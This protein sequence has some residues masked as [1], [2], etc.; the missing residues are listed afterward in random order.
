[1]EASLNGLAGTVKHTAS[2]ESIN[3]AKETLKRFNDKKD[4]PIVH[5]RE[6]CLAAFELAFDH[7]NEKHFHYAVDGVQVLLRDQTYHDTITEETQNSLPSQVL[8]SMTGIDEW[9]SQLQCKCITLLV[10][11]VCS[12]EL[13]VSMS[14]VEQCIQIYKRLYG[15]S[16]E[17][18]V[19]VACRAATTQSLS[20]YFSNRYAACEAQQEA[21]AVYMDV[22]KLLEELCAE[23]EQMSSAHEQ[24][25]ISLDAI[26][27]LLTTSNLRILNHQPFVNLL[28]EKLCPLIILLLG[29]PD[30]G[31]S[32][33]KISDSGGN[34]DPVGEG[35]IDFAL[36]PS[37]VTNPHTWRALYQ[38]VD[39]LIR[40]MIYDPSL[41]SSLEALFHKAFLFPRL[42]Q[43]SEALKLIKKILGDGS[44]MSKIAKSCVATKSLSIWRMLMTCIVECTNPQLELSIDSVK[45]VVSMLDGMKQLS[46]HRFFTDGE[47]KLIGDTFSCTEDTIV[48][49][50]SLKCSE[51]HCDIS[52]VEE[53]TENVFEQTGNLVEDPMS[54]KLRKLEQKFRCA[55]L[56]T[57]RSSELDESSERNTAK[58]FVQAF[59]ENLDIIAAPKN[60]LSI[61]EAILQFASDFY[62]NF[63]SV[64]A[65]A[66]KSRSKIQ[67]EFLNT[68]AIYLTTYAALC[69]ISRPETYT[70]EDLKKTVLNSGSVVHVA[71][72]WLEKV[73]DSLK[74]AD[75]HASQIT[76]ILKNV[77]NDFDGQTKG[78]LSDVEKLKRIKNRQE[79]V[80]C[81]EERNVARWMISSAWH[82][83]IDVLSTFLAVKEK[84]KT[85]EKIREAISVSICGM[86]NLC[87]VAQVLGLESRCG[88]IFEQLVETSC[89]LEDLRDDAIAADNEKK[90]TCTSREHLL[91]M[92]LVLDEARIAIHASACWKHIIRCSEYVWELEKYI[93]GALCYE[94]PSRLKFLRRKTEEKED[95]KEE[96]TSAADSSIENALGDEPNLSVH[97]LNRAICVLIAK[98]DRFYSQVCRELCLPALHDLCV[99]I[100]SSS[101]NR[102]FYSAQKH[103]HL[104]APVSL[105]SRISDI[106]STLS[107]RPLIHQMFIYPLV[108]AHFVKVCQCDQESRI[109]ASALAE[110]VT[111]L[112]LAESPGMSFNQTLIVPFQTASCSENC[113]EE[114]KEQ[115]LS[116]LSQ[117]VLSQ[118]DKIGSGWKPL[119]GS[120]K[121]VGAAR[122]EKVHWCA[123]D[124]ISS[125]LRIDS[126]PILSSSI[127]ECVPCVVNLLQNSEDSSE[128]SSAALR[129]LPNIYS[130]IL[131]LYS[132]PHIPN[133]HLLHRS[134]LRSKCLDTVEMEQDPL[135][136]PH[137]PLPWDD[138]QTYEI[139]A[140]ELFLTFMDQI[141][142][143]LLTSSTTTQ[144]NLLDMIGRLLVDISSKPLGGDSGGVC[145]SAVIL[146]Y[147]QKWIRRPDVEEVKILKQVIGAC[148]QTVIDM[149][150]LEKMNL[151]KDRLLRDIC[152][153]I[154]ECV[155]FD[156]TC[157][158]APA[159]F[160]LIAT[161]SFTF[162]TQQWNIFSHFLATASSQSLRHIRLLNSFFVRSSTDENGDIGDVTSFNPEKLTFRQM[163]A[164]IQ[165][166]SSKK[167]RSVKQDEE[168]DLSS[169]VALIMLSHGADTH[170]LEIH[171]IV[172]ALFTHC[173]LLQLIASILLSEDSNPKLKAS[174]IGTTTPIDPKLD[175]SIYPVLYSILNESSETSID[176]DT[177]PAVGSLLSRMLGID[178]ANLLKIYVSSNLIKTMSLLRRFEKTKNQ[179]LLIE[180]AQSVKAR[181]VELKNVEFEVSTRRSALVTREHAITQ[182]HLVPVE[183]SEENAYKLV[184]QEFVDDALS[185]Y[186]KHRER[187]KP[188]IPDRRNPFQ[189]AL[190]DVDP[191]SISNK[192]QKKEDYD[193]VRLA[194]H[195]D[196]CLVPLRYVA[197]NL[198]REHLPDFLPAITKI[199]LSSPDLAIRQLTVDFMSRLA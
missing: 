127:L 188:F 109:A 175:D 104:T 131:Y 162:S 29:I 98:V 189:H 51:R 63:C 129:L 55:P 174:L 187:L 170:R 80:D 96:K 94:K 155:L 49:S 27:A 171:S 47:R 92:Q 15:K 118:A 110:V 111:R 137:G 160:T 39:Q 164:A 2:K 99:A 75:A 147:V 191:T 97:S 20:A 50:F 146:P 23:V 12:N 151:W 124:V 71:N 45:T 133:Y 197:D 95:D 167:G 119:F 115:L 128:I 6:K 176:F 36:A 177:R 156:K 178:H 139:A 43:R 199:V 198:L 158:V 46:T 5:L 141:C 4:V 81:T 64:H 169:G 10:E 140:V 62:E 19:Q 122:D 48:N 114:T 33:T 69:Y 196:I 22:G 120:L 34:E 172:S 8:H 66:Y 91:A 82:M 103:I 117:L 26:C 173:L 138:K 125:Y 32:S 85:R 54:A 28:W 79:E 145:M 168:E 65:D 134:D 70:L 52:T 40:L 83:I 182:Y 161:N 90:S 76:P 152:A 11:M 142:G 135:S 31:I 67:Q 190:D 35:Q 7:G 159:Y 126:P 57:R 37:V 17:E 179:D 1:M 144:K 56:S 153:L 166:F 24:C 113:S 60:T 107:H 149:L 193:E 59:S 112:L 183:N 195:R 73:Y 13:K 163:I 136:I 180:T 18:R 148:T 101:E 25:L 165:V 41:A 61:D 3:V 42:D 106:I 192:D 38:I 194:A 72:G 77:I 21:I 86:R 150:E 44:K 186:D 84:R 185:E 100:V 121:A 123:I 130:L 154:V 16:E 143:T 53:D 74:L 157:A 9:K 68:D 89:C 58:R 88:W 108:S 30:K 184:S 105:L 78:L 181:G 93:Y 116:S 87:A 132:T 14:D 102:V